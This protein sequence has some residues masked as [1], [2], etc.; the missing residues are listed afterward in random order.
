[1]VKNFGLDKYVW[2][3]ID[4]AYTETEDEGEPLMKAG[5]KNRSR[6]EE[7]DTVNDL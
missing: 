7:N 3:Q 5:Q 1:M 6:I 2:P 4:E